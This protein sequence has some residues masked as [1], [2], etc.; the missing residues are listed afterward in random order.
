MTAEK[1]H[2]HEILDLVAAH[3]E[4]LSMENLAHLANEKFGPDVRFFT[5][6][7]EGMDLPDLLAFLLERDKIRQRD[8]L[9]FSGA[10]PA[11]NHDHH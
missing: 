6:S 2:G 3:P 7:T 10:S 5:C 1:I 8:G 11:C 9:L 4:G